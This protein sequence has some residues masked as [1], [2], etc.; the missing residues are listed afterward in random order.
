MEDLSDVTFLEQRKKVVEVV[1]DVVVIEV[2]EVAEE[3][4]EGVEEM[5][6]LN[7][8]VAEWNFERF[9]V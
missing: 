2:E 6:Y 7:L 4:A 5:M 9:E 8:Q 1:V 3:V